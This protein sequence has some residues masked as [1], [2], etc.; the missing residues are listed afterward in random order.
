[1]HFCGTV[2]LTVPLLYSSFIQIGPVLTEATAAEAPLY[3]LRD[4]GAV[5]LS[6]ISNPSVMR[7]ILRSYCKMLTTWK[8]PLRT[9]IPQSCTRLTGTCV[10]DLLEK[11]LSVIWDAQMLMPF[12]LSRYKGQLKIAGSSKHPYR[13]NTLNKH[14]NSPR[15]ITASFLFYTCTN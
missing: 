10:P 15:F 6:P 8:Y 4:L 11:A 7:M 13:Y 3:Y 2:P 1:V 9:K 5:C 14:V 12:S